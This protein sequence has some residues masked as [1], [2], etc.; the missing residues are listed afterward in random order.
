MAAKA[1]VEVGA[2]GVTVSTSAV[3]LLVDNINKEVTLD[4]IDS[5]YLWVGP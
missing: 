1:K 2:A 5:M 3:V 4:K